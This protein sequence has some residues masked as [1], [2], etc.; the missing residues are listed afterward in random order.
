MNTRDT[1]KII[2]QNSD[3]TLDISE[4]SGLNDILIKPLS[5]VL[6]Y[7]HNIVNGLQSKLSLRDPENMGNDELD[8]IGA[9][10]MVVRKSG[11]KATGYGKISV[12]SPISII[13]PT[14]T[15]FTTSDGK[16][17]VTTRQYSISS[18]QM[19]QN[20][21]NNVYV[22]DRIPLEATEKGDEYTIDPEEI[23]DVLNVNFD[24]IKAWN[25]EAFSKG[26]DEESNES[27]Y[28]RIMESITSETTFSELSF[29][30]ILSKQFDFK[31]LKITGYGDSE[32]VR[33]L[34]IGGVDLINYY[35]GD[36]FGKRKGYVSSPY[37]ENIAGFFIVSGQEPPAIT[38][39]SL[40]E[41]TDS[42]Y[43]ALY[44]ADNG[45]TTDV[46]S[47]N[48]LSDAFD[49][50]NLTT[51]WFLS[52]AKIGYNKL[53]YA[54]EITIEN[55]TVKLGINPEATADDLSIFINRHEIIRL[56]NKLKDIRFLIDE[57]KLA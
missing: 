18:G 52:D 55:H 6:N 40:N 12:T 1:I 13:L 21:T 50:D 57:N 47:L 8:A 49:E 24:F 10:Y 2:L 48:L 32:M 25:P 5:T 51:N 45:L 20:Y 44:A 19:A 36:Y 42:Q 3:P 17:F 29:K 43:L 46:E 4:G 34:K 26:V 53:K 41:Y 33:D 37:N 35:K 11:E 31:D 56:N 38:N 23:N 22:T 14:G 28:T 9:N 7:Y 54:D 39:V 16:L 15:T 30:K 27:F